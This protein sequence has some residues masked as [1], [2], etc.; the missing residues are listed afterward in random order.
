MV[1]QLLALRPSRKRRHTDD[2]GLDTPF[3]DDLKSPV[4]Q[5]DEQPSYVELPADEETPVIEEGDGGLPAP[6]FSPPGLG[7][8]FRYLSPSINQLQYKKLK[9]WK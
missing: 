9:M 6:M 2:G 8:K 3:D 1:K 4:L 7:E 5:D